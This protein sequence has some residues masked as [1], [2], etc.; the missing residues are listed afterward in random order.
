M[1]SVKGRKSKGEKN[2]DTLQDLSKAEGKQK[3]IS[4]TT[5]AGVISA[6]MNQNH[7]TRDL[8]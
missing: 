8:G 5:T 4:G 2:V 6:N 1:P 7:L 3:D